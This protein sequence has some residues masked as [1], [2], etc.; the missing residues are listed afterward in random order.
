MRT[1]IPHYTHYPTVSNTWETKD[2]SSELEPDE[3]AV[4]ILMYGNPVGT[5][6]RGCRHPSQTSGNWLAASVT[7]SRCW[8]VLRFL[9]SSQELD[10]YGS[11]VAGRTWFAIVAA[12]TENDLVLYNNHPT[13]YTF[14]Q[15][16]TG[17]EQCS[18]WDLTARLPGGG[19]P[20][21]A[22]INYEDNDAGVYQHR[23]VSHGSTTASCIDRFAISQPNTMLLGIDSNDDGSLYV[24]NT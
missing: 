21:H 14:S 12:F 13:E 22:F 6:Q 20:T 2:L 18:Q 19:T 10:F 1:L 24:N 7:N 3:I 11:S 23:A 17:G 4:W 9:N 15:P 8:S 16:L 5:Q